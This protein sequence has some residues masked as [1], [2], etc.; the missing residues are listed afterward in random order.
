MTTWKRG[1]S[2]LVE[3]FENQSI[4]VEDFL[5]SIRDHPPAR[6]PGTAVFMTTRP[7]SVPRTLLHN[8]K[9]NRVLHERVIV[10]AIE[11]V[12]VPTVD[13]EERY[14]VIEL[15]TDFHRVVARFGFVEDPDVPSACS[16]SE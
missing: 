4:D 7:H 15:G 10:L 8:L 5:A 13:E 16:S 3:R 1:R 14:E 2:I 12:D 9:H 11:N 6:V